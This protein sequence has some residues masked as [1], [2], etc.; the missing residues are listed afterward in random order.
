M[1]GRKALAD[2]AQDLGIWEGQVFKHQLPGRM[3]AN[4]RNLALQHQTGGALIHQE[5]RN[6][7][8]GALALLRHRHDNNEV[9]DMGA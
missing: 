9:S 1:H 2:F 3:S 6:S 5:G 7:A 4:D 8:T